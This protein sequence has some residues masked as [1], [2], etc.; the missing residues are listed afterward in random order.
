[1]TTDQNKPYNF[2]DHDNF[3]LDLKK[4]TELYENSIHAILS[5]F[6]PMMNMKTNESDASSVRLC[7]GPGSQLIYSILAKE[8]HH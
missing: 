7:T 8:K 1:M 4:L 2:S 5:P 6:R 3:L